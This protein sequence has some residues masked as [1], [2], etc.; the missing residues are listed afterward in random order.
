ML[1]LLRKKIPKKTKNKVKNFKIFK[2]SKHF[3][4]YLQS[5]IEDLK[6][7]L[8]KITICRFDKSEI[9]I[10]GEIYKISLKHQNFAQRSLITNNN[11]IN[12][13]EEFISNIVF[14][15]RF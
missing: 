3:K 9:K 12:F 10:S 4:I 8:F 1:N 6:F 15:Y 7:I 14:E 2:Q 13:Y 11:K 5:N